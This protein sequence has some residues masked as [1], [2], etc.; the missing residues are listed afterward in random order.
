MGRLFFSILVVALFFSLDN[1]ARAQVVDSS[2]EGVDIVVESKYNADGHDYG[3]DYYAT[4]SNEYS[5]CVTIWITEGHNI[6]DGLIDSNTPMIV[7]PNETAYL[8]WVVQ[9]NVNYPSSWNY[10]WQM[11][12]DC[13]PE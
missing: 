1:V 3:Y 2:F 8:G 6:Y 12:T 5:V 13:L 9:R 10:E 4:N 7:E 11:S